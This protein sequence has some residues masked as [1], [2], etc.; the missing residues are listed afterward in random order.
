MPP[1]QH[2]L[3]LPHRQ[4]GVSFLCSQPGAGAAHPRLLWSEGHQQALTLA[5]AVW[6]T[7]RIFFTQSCS[8]SCESAATSKDQCATD[9]ML[10][11]KT[12]SLLFLPSGRMAGRE[13]RAELRTH[14]PGSH[15]TPRALAPMN[16]L[17]PWGGGA[18][19]QAPFTTENGCIPALSPCH[20]D[21]VL[22]PSPPCFQACVPPRDPPSGGTVIHSACKGRAGRGHSQ[23]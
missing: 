15:P 2:I 13:R 10:M 4:P 6:A 1:T 11:E 16:S 21:H 20:P 5:S 22:C 8:S 9:A 3:S 7:S 14:V 12:K 19:C 17:P 23:G 18:V